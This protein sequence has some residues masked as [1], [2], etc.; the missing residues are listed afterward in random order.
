MPGL[1][2]G[3]AWYMAFIMP[4]APCPVYGLWAL[5]TLPA[6]FIDTVVVFVTSTS[7]LAR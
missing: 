5:L 3:V 6:M 7:R 1:E 4:D 2:N